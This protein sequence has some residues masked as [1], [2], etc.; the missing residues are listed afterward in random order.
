[1]PCRPSPSL[2]GAR[3]SQMCCLPAVT[4]AE[5]GPASP[6]AGGCWLPAWFP[7]CSVSVA[8]VRP[9]SN[10]SETRSLLRVGPIGLWTWALASSVWRGSDLG[11]KVSIKVNAMKAALT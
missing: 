9:V 1:M 4:L 3:Y 7:E 6:C 10:R 2:E 5:R 8:N 11:D